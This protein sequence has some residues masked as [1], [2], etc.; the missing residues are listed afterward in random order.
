[1]KPFEWDDKKNR[2][3]KQERG[4][5]FE[6]VVLAI[7]DGRLVDI[8]AHPNPEKYRKQ[9][10][11]IIEIDRYIYAVPYEEQAEAIVLKTIFPNRK[12]T[13]NYMGKDR[14]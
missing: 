2:R 3:L 6:D 7:L 1:M 12:Y 8:V 9:R 11:Y 13:K 10:I 4:V 5:G 14:K